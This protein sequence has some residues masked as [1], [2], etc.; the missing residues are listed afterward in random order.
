MTILLM[1]TLGVV[2]ALILLAG[3]AINRICP[4]CNTPLPQRRKP[5][6]ARQTLLGGWTCRNCGCEVDRHGQKLKS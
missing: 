1:S 4:Q 5:T 2:F 3:F 6:S